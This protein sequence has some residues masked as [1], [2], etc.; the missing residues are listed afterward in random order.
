MIP[1]VEEHNFGDWNIVEEP[2]ETMEGLKE[3]MCTVCKATEAVKIS[4]DDTT[5][6]EED[7][8]I[9][10]TQEGNSEGQNSEEQTTEE[11]SSEGQ[12]SENQ[13]TEGNNNAKPY[14]VGAAIVL[15]SAGVIGAVVAVLKKRSRG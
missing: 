7:T 5:S 13:N 8:T 9:E 15:P 14:I 10:D 3:R 4:V 11:N 12:N 6:T 1:A 2:T